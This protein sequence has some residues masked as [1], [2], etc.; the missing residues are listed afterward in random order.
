MKFPSARDLLCIAVIASS[1]ACELSTPTEPQKP[2]DLE[3]DFC[4]SDVPVWF[5]YQNED[6]T[7]ARR[8]FE[9]GEGTFRFTAT[10]RVIIGMVWENGSDRRTEFIYATNEELAGLS[11]VGCL[12]EFGGKVVNGTVT[13]VGSN[14]V[15]VVSLSFA[16]VTRQS[17][18]TSY[19]LTNLPDRP[20][21]LIASR[22]STTATSQTADRV[23][24][25]RT[26]NFTNNGTVP[27]IDFVNG[28]DVIQ[29]AIANAN[30]SGILSGEFAY[31]QSNLFSQLE[32]SHAMSY[33]ESL[34]N[35]TVA[36]AALP[37]ASLAAGDY[38]D[39]FLLSINATTGSVRGAENFFRAPG[40]QTLA[41]GP[42]LSDPTITDI[43][44]NAGP[45][46]LRTQLGAQLSYDDAVVVRYEQQVDL[47]SITVAQF[48]T[49]EYARGTPSVW[50]L[51][52]PNLR[53]APGWVDDWELRTGAPIS[54]TVTAFGGRA[55]LLFGAKPEDGE[56]IRYAIRQ[57]DPGAAPAGAGQHGLR[58]GSLG[59]VYTNRLRLHTP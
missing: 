6:M 40:T 53:G 19:S 59:S 52:L 20:V 51:E 23:V 48:I 36:F 28:S 30:V 33:A 3:L 44:A 56:F 18:N 22:Q 12:E 10:N 46:I 58:N 31:L 14:Q 47:S 24:V 35:G 49:S 39:L 13:G 32:T 11:S 27:P 1:A 7:S 2:I 41:L 16:S 26:Q 25:R 55:E 5:V 54:W 21:D 50:V 45:V 4:A 37:Q 42:V 34:S 38:H 17:G 9:D 8:V 57:S 15:A 29:P 43:S